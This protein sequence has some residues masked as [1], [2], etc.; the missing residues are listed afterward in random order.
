MTASAERK[1][2]L[3]T[4]GSRGIGRATAVLAAERGWDVGINYARDAAAAERTAQAVR[5][6]RGR[7]WAVA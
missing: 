2:V 4:G 3:I 1:A 5:A 6:A 7:A